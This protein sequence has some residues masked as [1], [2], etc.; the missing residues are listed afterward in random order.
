MDFKIRCSAIGKIMTEPRA[1][2]ESLSETTKQ[3]L[4]EWYL[5]E[6]YGRKK[7]IRSK[8]LQKG[9]MAEEKSITLLNDYF[10][11]NNREIFLKKNPQSFA[12]DDITGTPDLIFDDEVYDIKSSWDIF[13]FPF[14]DTEWKNK[15]YYYQLQ[16][17][18]ALTGLKKAALCYVLTNTPDCLIY[19][20]ARRASY[21]LGFGGE[22]TAE[23]E[24]EAIRNHTFDDI[25][26][27]DR[28]RI[29][30]IERDDDV[31]AKIREKVSLCRD[32]LSQ[33]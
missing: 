28:I 15:D 17:Y 2:S 19:D 8:F 7:D 9:I 6:K 18:L 27:S 22:I 30:P 20:E 1:K 11:A 14:F 13:T 5:S 29:F 10:L 21:D 3:Y 33:F 16:G 23:I 31:I 25:P 32:F 26:L 4:Q 24:E 12:D